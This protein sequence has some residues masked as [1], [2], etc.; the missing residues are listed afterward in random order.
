VKTIR[1]SR[2]I[3]ASPR[4]VWPLLA[5]FR[6][7]PAWGPT[8]TAVAS[9]A[10][11]VSPGVR[12]RVRTPVGIW[13]PFEITTVEVEK[14]WT[15]RV[16]GIRATGHRLDEVAADRCLV[17]FSVSFW[18]APYGAVLALGLRRLQALAESVPRT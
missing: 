2:E 9:D 1:V 18:L 11:E 3:H 8:V 16:A 12:G 4:T 15:W 13:L 6:H 10:D 17:E 14:S 5:E 7:W